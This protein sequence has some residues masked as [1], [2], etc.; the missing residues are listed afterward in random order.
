M[1]GADRRRRASFE[2]RFTHRGD[3]D[4]PQPAAYPRCCNAAE[5]G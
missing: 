2:Q 5:A 1:K 3:A 4:V